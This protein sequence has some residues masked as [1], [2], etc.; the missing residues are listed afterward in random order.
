MLLVESKELSAR[1]VALQ[2]LLNRDRAIAPKLVTDGS[3][4]TKTGKAVDLFRDKVMHQSGPRLT[5]DPAL[6]RFLLDR[7]KLQ[8]V[9][10]VDVTDPSLLAEIV[11]SISNW[12]DPIVL[13]GMSN[14]I[15]Q[16]VAGVRARARGE[17]SLLMLRLHGHGAPGLIAISH[18]SRRISP[19]ID[20]IA[21]QSILNL[22]VLPVLLPLLQQL[23][24]LF[25][26]FGFV[27]LHSCRVAEG[28]SGV[29]FVRKLA[30]ALGVPVRA[31]L[32]KQSTANAFNLTGQTF[33]GCPG[34]QELIDWALSRDEAMR[35]LSLLP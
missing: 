18:G 14:G 12:T 8:I 29:G 23:G 13:G 33:T 32:S 3:F 28:G 6:W 35:K 17:K 26:N 11:P 20:P 2:I 10:A 25:C 1:V 7:A 15:A 30:D 19:G 9:D 16:L 4:G 31:G 24:P 22:A 5:A 27:E 21:A 34:G